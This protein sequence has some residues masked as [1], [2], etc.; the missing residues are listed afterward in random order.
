MADRNPPTRTVL[1]REYIATV[2]LDLIDQ[3]GLAKFS[4]RKLGAELGV[5]PMAV[6]RHYADQ[7]ALYDGIAEL[8]FDRLDPDSLPW[9]KDWRALCTAYCER[10][11]GTLLDHPHAVTVFASRPVRSP[12]AIA[13]G[14][15]MIEALRDAGFTPAY[16]LQ[17]ARCLREFTIGHVLTMAVLSVGAERRSRKPAPDDPTYNLLAEAAD[18]AA[19]G[20]HFQLGLTAMLDGFSAASGRTRARR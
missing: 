3:I 17:V 10:L 11:R 8:L 9:A 12:A 7:E 15:R 20:E 1:N 4:M 19:P 16:A 13:T 14:N 2:A 5:D 18:G 6:Y